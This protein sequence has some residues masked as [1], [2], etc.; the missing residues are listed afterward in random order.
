MTGQQPNLFSTTT[1]EIVQRLREQ[2]QVIATDHAAFDMVC[3]QGWVRV[4]LWQS[5]T[6]VP[7]E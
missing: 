5:D 7:Q 4:R 6:L 3:F 1:S 2:F